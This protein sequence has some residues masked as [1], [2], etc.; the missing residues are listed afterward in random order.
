LK[1]SG[2]YSFLEGTSNVDRFGTPPDAGAHQRVDLHGSYAPRSG[3]LQN[4]DLYFNWRNIFDE[5]ILV[6]KQ[7]NPGYGIM[8]IDQ[9]MVTVGVRYTTD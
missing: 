2:N 6:A 7:G 5:R 8:F 1:V 9:P 4:F 3:R